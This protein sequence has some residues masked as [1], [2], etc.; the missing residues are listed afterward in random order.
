MLLIILNPEM[1]Q[2]ALYIDVVG[3][4]IFLMLLEVQLLALLGM[5][6]NTKIK[7]IF[8]YII[9]LYSKYGLSFSWKTIKE[10]PENLMLVVPSTTSL[11][12]MLV[13]LA[14]VGIILNVH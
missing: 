3:L 11:M 7:P 14:A 2:L 6:F 1:A 4:E 12:H 5:F 13:F 8:S 10:K 9:N